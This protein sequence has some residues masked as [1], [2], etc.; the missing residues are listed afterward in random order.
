MSHRHHGTRAKY[1]VDRCRCLPCRAANSQAATHMYKQKAYGRWQPYVDAHPTREHIQELR[2]AG[3][4]LK[5][6]GD[7]AGVS[8]SS[9]AKV[10][11]GDRNRGPSKRVRPE[12]EAR[13]LAVAVDAAL[14]PGAYVSAQETWL[15]IMGLV[16]RGYTF[17]WIAQQ[18]TSPT[19]RALQIGR[20]QCTAR[21][22]RA[23]AALAEQLE[24]T[25]GPSLRARRM[26]ERYEWT[27]LLG[28]DE[29]PQTQQT[30]PEILAEDGAWLVDNGLS[31]ELA[32][33]RLGVT[34]DYLE[35]LLERRASGAA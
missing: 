34:A 22:A 7:V 10:I 18:V 9:L 14:A 23:I 26:A 25:F 27:A 3:V 28:L 24:D 29:Q 20:W 13:V 1:V 19:A 8:H 30:R 15:H 2:A 32:A 4:G 33:N 11:Y 21:N 17:T 6:I 35:Q 5:R 31:V 12:T 16:A